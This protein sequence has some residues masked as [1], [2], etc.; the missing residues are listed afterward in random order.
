MLAPPLLPETANFTIGEVNL[1][2]RL[3]QLIR[4]LVKCDPKM[5]QD[6]AP[7]PDPKLM[8]NRSL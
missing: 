8:R 2:S 5:I 4:S 1:V 6:S 3:S 7:G